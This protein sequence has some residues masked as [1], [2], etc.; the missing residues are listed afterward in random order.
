MF[1]VE[2]GAVDFVSGGDRKGGNEEANEGDLG[3]EAGH[4]SDDHEDVTRLSV[5]TDNC[6]VTPE[7]RVLTYRM[8]M[9]KK[10]VSIST[11]PDLHITPLII[12]E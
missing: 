12:K 6:D 5:V 8:K 1:L 3:F 11:I 9:R 4:S 7:V 10:T 2:A